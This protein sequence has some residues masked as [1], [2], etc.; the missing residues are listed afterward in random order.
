MKRVL[1]LFALL[2]T[3]GVTAFAQSTHTVTGKILDE[4]ALGLPGASISVRGMQIGTVSDVNGDFMLDVPDGNGDFVVAAQGYNTRI[5]SETDGI[6]NVKL[7]HISRELEG[8][9]VTQQT[10]RRDKRELGYNTS[11]VNYDE[12]T[13][14]GNVSVISALQGK[15]AG[16]NITSSTGGP[17][18]SSRIILRGE[19]SFMN[20]NNAL[21]I[22]DGVITNNHDRTR[23]SLHGADAN[24]SQ[25]NQVDF[26]NSANDL[27][28]EE[29][30]SVHVLNGAQAT[31]L[32]GSAG[33]HGAVIYTTKTGKH[34]ESGKHSKLDITY[35]ATYTESDV[36]KYSDMQHL[37]G[38]GNIYTD[39]NGNMPQFGSWGLQFDNALRPWGQVING[40]QLVKPYSDQPDN[41]KSF[42]NHGKALNNFVSLSSGTERSAYFLSIN[43]LNSSGVIP[44]TFHNKYSIRFNGGVQLSNHFYSAVN[45]NYLNTYSRA[46]EN[47]HGDG[48]ALN[49]VYGMARDIPV[50]E[51]SDYN[52]KYY[53]MRYFDTAGT[54]RYGNYTKNPFWMAKQYDNRIKTDRLLGDFKVGY[55]RGDFNVYN[56]VGADVSSE[57]S[58]YNTP[59]FDV[60]PTDQTYVSSNGSLF[61]S[62]STVYQPNHLTSA[63][64]YT[65][66]NYNSYRIY[67]DLVANF[68]HPLS[69]NFGINAFVGNSVSV[70]H[71]QTLSGI[72]DPATN[73]L[74]IPN[75]YNLQNNAGPVIGYNNTYNLRTV[76]LYGD[77]IFNFQKELFM[78]MTGRNDWSSSL[79][80]DRSSFF[81]PGA[82]AAWVFTERLKGG[83]F[84][85]KVLNYG[86]VRVAAASV[87]NTPKPYINNPSGFT[88]GVVNSQFGSVVSP[89]NGV[90]TYQMTNTI[91]DQ[92]LTPEQTREIE[93][94]TD[95]GFL[96]NR[97]SFSFTYY[98]RMTDNLIAA[99]PLPPSSGFAYNYANIGSVSNRGVELAATGTPIS[100]RWGLKWDVFATYTHNTSNVESLKSG[101]DRVS[102]GGM[103][104]LDIVAAVGHPYGTFYA[105]DI[106]YWKDPKSGIWHPVVD[107]NTGLPIA[108]KNPVY[109]GTF[110]PKFMAS[111]GTSLSYKGLK[112]HVLF[113]TKQGGQFYSQKKMDMDYNGLSQETTVNYRQS[114]VWANSVYEVANTN[115]FLKNNTKFRPYDFYTGTE[116][117]MAA[118]GLVNASYVRMQEISLS[119]RIP[120][121]YY[122]HTPFGGLEAGIFGNNLL[123]WTATSNHYGD[124]EEVSAGATGNGQG[125]NYIANPSLRNYGA[126]VKVNF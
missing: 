114:Y 14:A 48:S 47:G 39:V 90:P 110:Q 118:Q 69:T 97:I 103:N 92:N 84:R 16:A 75:F 3:A 23:S 57:K 87:G 41:V 29:I 10:I 99:V 24:F 20:D 62:G 64:G 85:E 60:M 126:F 58:T 19:N 71:D 66:S 59:E 18:G 26:G 38:Q 125:F 123:L 21:I 120:T 79:N 117:T 9:V 7:E 111:W 113:T 76:G 13:G 31:A 91:G 5:V 6:V 42:F 33:A 11:V 94:G 109:R 25:L 55:K 45:V 49:T 107:Q 96:R 56:R 2:L 78:E 115:S 81:Y 15:V 106:Q 68:N 105:A 100:T 51:M 37:Y 8:T 40:K 104:G 53:S 65:E 73:G 112:L 116:Q 34:K 101:V 121:K 28:P 82:N 83:A 119:Y 108:T 35:K 12:L 1:L 88:Q 22:V 44:N 54:E 70:A 46:A 36:L 95:L 52:N 102:L 67:N 61:N 74:V 98:A 50:W 72:I 30:E 17:G 77:V 63:G 32:Y 124:P 93:V 89:F 4:H 122:K 86:K 27:N 80:H 43:S